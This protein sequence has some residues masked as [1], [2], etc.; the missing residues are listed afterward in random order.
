MKFRNPLTQMN[1]KQQLVLLF[2][3]LVIPLFI[4]N[5]YGNSTA[6]QILKRHVTNAYIELNQQNFKL[7]SRDIETINKV[8]S[9]VVQ[10]EFIQQLSTIG[11]EDVLTRVKHYEKIEVMLNTYSQE[12]DER[13]PLY[14]SLYVYDP[15]NAYFL[16]RIIPIR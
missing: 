5:S 11:E 15:D 16:P 1:V 8:T 7:I 9:T 13:E 2:L 6:G 3:V 14:Y 10:N 4:L 12:S